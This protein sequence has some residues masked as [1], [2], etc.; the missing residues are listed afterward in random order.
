MPTLLDEPPVESRPIADSELFGDDWIYDPISRCGVHVEDARKGCP[1]GCK[2]VLYVTR[3]REFN[4]NHV[5][6]ERCY[7]DKAIRLAKRDDLVYGRRTRPSRE[8]AYSKS[9]A[10]VERHWARLAA[11]AKG[12]SNDGR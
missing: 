4:Q 5:Y 7:G 1:C 11:K 3:G 2:S 10:E 12:A 6:C 9:A 8:I